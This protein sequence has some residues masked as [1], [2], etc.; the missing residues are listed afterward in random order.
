MKM[1]A[2]TSD[3]PLRLVIKHENIT[4]RKLAEEERLESARRLKRLAAHLE[5]VREE[6]SATIAREVHDE[7]GG[8]L[9]MAKLGLAT[10]ADELQ[11][12]TPQHD[13]LLRI[14]DQVNAALQT[15]KRISADLRPATLDTLGFIATIKWYATRFSQMT[16]IDIDLHLPEYVRLSRNSSTAAFRIVQEALTNVAKHADASLV[17]IEMD[18]IDDLLII[19]IRDNGIGLNDAYR[20]KHESFGVIGMLERARNLGGQLSITST[21]GAGTCLV[22]RIPLDNSDEDGESET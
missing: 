11:D 14:L 1:S 17:C 12:S 21:P 4:A 8:T 10:L 13:S 6:Q 15:V 3:G 7:L 18:K 9:T 2:F 5:T 22:L 20:L 19:E 16:G